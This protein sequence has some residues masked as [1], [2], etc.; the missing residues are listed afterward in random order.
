MAYEGTPASEFLDT[1]LVQEHINTVIQVAQQEIARMVETRIVAPMRTLPSLAFDSPLEVVF[2]LWW[3]AFDLLQI[4]QAQA[5]A[6]RPQQEV[7]LGDK[8]YRVDFLIQPNDNAIAGH[9]SWQP[10]AVEVDGHAFHEK[11]R[12]Q[13]SYRNQRDRALQQGNWKVFHFSY[14]EFVDHPVNCVWEVMAFAGKQHKRVSLEIATSIGGS[15]PTLGDTSDP[16]QS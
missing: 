15:A 3:S 1:D 7:Q 2:Y 4:A 13:V 5:I 14:A 12:E 6:C 10:I 16:Q 11:T 9:P 8:R